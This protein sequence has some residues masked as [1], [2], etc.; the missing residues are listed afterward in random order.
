[1]A[2]ARAYEPEYVA[3][4]RALMSRFLTVA[5]SRAARRVA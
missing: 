4:S 3:L 5:R 1:V 2:R